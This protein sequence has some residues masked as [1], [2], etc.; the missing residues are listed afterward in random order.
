MRKTTNRDTR[1]RQGLYMG[2]RIAYLLTVRSKDRKRLIQNLEDQ[3]DEACEL[4]G[5]PR[6]RDFPGLSDVWKEYN[7]PHKQANKGR[8]K[9]RS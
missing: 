6:I 7:A 5:V 1:F 9:K 8:A 4:D 3:H 2:L